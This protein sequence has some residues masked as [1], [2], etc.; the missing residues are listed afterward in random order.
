MIIKTFN[1]TNLR[2]TVIEVEVHLFQNGQRV[3]IGSAVRRLIPDWEPLEATVARALAK[4]V[5][6]LSAMPAGAV[7]LRD[8]GGLYV[9][10]N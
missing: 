6:W 7:N 8:T 2:N 3:V 4:A 10:R 1:V 9:A 5:T